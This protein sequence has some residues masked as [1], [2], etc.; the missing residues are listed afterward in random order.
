MFGRMLFE[1]GVGLIVSVYGNQYTF[2]SISDMLR[3]ERKQNHIK[4]LVK[5]TINRKKEWKT[6][7][8]TENKG[9]KQKIVNKYKY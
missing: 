7:I 1:N 5:T 6:K 9:N 4:S 8:G 2:L 3:R